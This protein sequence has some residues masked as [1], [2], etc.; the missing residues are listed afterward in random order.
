[1]TTSASPTPPRLGIDRSTLTF[2]VRHG[3]GGS[4]VFTVTNR[5]GGLLEGRV[6]GTVG[7]EWLR[8]EPLLLRL[9]GGESRRITVT[10]N[11][12]GLEPGVTF[13]SID[14]STNGGLS[15]VDVRVGLRV[16]RS[17]AAFAAAIGVTV[18]AALLAVVLFANVKDAPPAASAPSQATTAPNATLGANAGP[19]VGPA[20]TP[21]PAP[22]IDAATARTAITNVVR[23]SDRI[24]RAALVHPTDNALSSLS[25]AKTGPDLR[26]ARQE[27]EALSASGAYWT[28]TARDVVVGRPDLS[29]D[30]A[31]AT[32]FLTKTEQRTYNPVGAAAAPG[33]AYRYTLRYHLMA[34]SG[35]W[36]VD[37]V[38]VTGA[39]PLDAGNA[40]PN[41]QSVSARVLPVVVHVEADSADQTDVG[42]GFVIHST[43]SGSD[44]LTNDH[45]VVGANT[46]S[47]KRWVNN[48]YTPA[49]TAT[50]VWEDSVNDLAILHIN[51]GD[52]PSALWGPSATLQPGQAV[53]SIGYA[54]DLNG[55]PS[56]GA[57]IVSSVLRTDPSDGSGATFIGH[58]ATINPGNSGGPL[59]DMEGRV[60]GINRATLQNTQ[61]IFFAIPSSRALPIVLNHLGSNG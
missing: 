46:V 48:A 18:L 59:V 61:G 10:A 23:A 38:A 29:S 11:L 27:V 32:C 40:L 43:A 31:T 12:E 58:N 20:N 26:H 19:A 56:I 39:T 6:G 54:E 35:R 7:A 3:E 8:A 24:W 41:V 28:I 4:G 49:S 42:T 51:E 52:L 44:I 30:G 45:V 33:P 57:G 16:R 13:G 15:T 60:V 37:G 1:M 50:V 22:T 47:V 55:G 17:W 34:T 14:V 53:V 5:G 25:L 21:A 2:T 36:F 9:E